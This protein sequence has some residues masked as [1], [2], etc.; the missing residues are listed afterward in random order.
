[1]IMRSLR[2]S[3]LLTSISAA[4][5]LAA[6]SSE[7]KPVPT[8]QPSKPV[9]QKSEFQ[10]GRIALQKLY[11]TARGWA[12]DAEPIRLESQYRKIEGASATANPGKAAMWRA[13]FGSS[14]RQLQKPYMWSGLAGPDAPERGINPGA[15]DGFSAS[16]TF[17]HPF[18]LVYLKI[19]SD[20]AFEVAQQHGGSAL[21]KKNPDL[22]VNYVLDWDPRRSE[23]IWHIIYGQNTNDPDL[24]IAVDA[25]SGNYIRKES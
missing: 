16:N 18:N 23:L 5:L 1:M 24:Q 8:A 2:P 9:E 7:N 3:M 10:S 19:D 12:S 21:L 22:P 13:T 20:K 11:T 4:M 15:E 17:T 6:C 25:S 14:A